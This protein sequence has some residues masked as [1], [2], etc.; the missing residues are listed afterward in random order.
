MD[1]DFD[2]DALL[3]DIASEVS[4]IASEDTLDRHDR[5]R[6]VMLDHDEVV[7]QLEN[8]M[9]R[10]ES[11]A[12]ISRNWWGQLLVGPAS[13]S[14][15][16]RDHAMP[17]VLS[18]EY[19]WSHEVTQELR[20]RLTSTYEALQRAQRELSEAKAAY[21]EIRVEANQALREGCYVEFATR[22]GNQAAGGKG[23]ITK[24]TASSYVVT[25][26]HTASSWKYQDR[27]TVRIDISTAQR[28]V[29]SSGRSLTILWGPKGN[30]KR[31]ED[32]LIEARKREEQRQREQAAMERRN[33]AV[34][35]YDEAKRLDDERTH[36]V[37]TAPD[38][39][40]MTAAQ[41]ILA[42]YAAE[43]Q[44]EAD[45]LLAETL[46]ALPAYERPSILDAPPPSRDWTDYLEDE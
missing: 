2:I 9:C 13:N 3:D 34:T 40:A 28:G 25:L 46:A 26:D 27:E 29:W 20:D 39:A 14:W 32:A 42:R 31:R 36:T 4:S 43:V 6:Q 37:S 18:G 33:T 12:G 17:A 1:N 41:R 38:R 5:L 23:E 11:A 16:D 10:A 45:A 24:I 15:L 8:E 7:S 44:A 22:F 19:G 21:K 35:A 30:T